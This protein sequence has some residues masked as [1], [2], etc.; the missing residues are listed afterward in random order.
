MGSTNTG[1]TNTRSANIWRSRI[2]A[3]RNRQVNF[4]YIPLLLVLLP[5][6][7]TGHHSRAEFN[8]NILAEIEGEVV[9]VFWRNPHVH[10]SVRS[11]AADGSG[12]TWQLEGVD[13]VSLDRRGIP[14]DAVRV[15]DRVRAT[16]YRS[17]RRDDYLDVQRVLVP[18]G[19]EILFGFNTEPIWSDVVLGLGG[20]M[21]T[22]GTP[23]S[24]NLAVDDIYRVWTRTGTNLPNFEDLPLTEA[25]LAAHSGYD[26]LE[27]DPL[28]DCETPG[29]PRA[30]TFA[31]PHPIAFVEGDGEIRLEM[32]YF[33]LVRT[34][35]VGAG[36]PPASAPATPMGYSVGHWDGDTLVVTTTRID[37]PYFDIYWRGPTRD[38]A[39]MIGF[40]QSTSVRLVE[41]FNLDSDNGE[42]TYDITIS[43]PLTLTEPLTLSRYL[44]WEYRPNMRIEPFGCEVQVPREP[45]P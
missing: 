33:N 8:P 13:I 9:G 26:P 16:G 39:S 4:N 19:T 7:A 22:A 20:G 29:M 10:L 32:E 2:A 28:L 44:V 43:D 34:I 5:L 14:R 1:S 41:R 45:A 3:H 25:A 42:L 6:S 38:T 11:E 17:N 40:P 36:E 18:D 24:G 27:D 15:G 12:K 31:G 23:P 30:M 35:H 21:G 37:Y